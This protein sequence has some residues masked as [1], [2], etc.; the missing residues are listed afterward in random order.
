MECL[1]ISLKVFLKTE[2]SSNIDFSSI[3]KS[4][5]I[6][7]DFPMFNIIYFRNRALH[8]NRVSLL[9]IDHKI[10][11]FVKLRFYEDFHLFNH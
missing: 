3:E 9:E 10:L 6:F 5:H 4:S 8:L 7:C 11:L 1:V 2:D